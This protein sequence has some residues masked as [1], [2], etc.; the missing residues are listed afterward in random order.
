MSASRATALCGTPERIGLYIGFRSS[1]T[2][3]RLRVICMSCTHATTGAASTLHTLGS[4][5]DLRTW[6]TCFQRVATS[7]RAGWST[8]E[9]RSLRSLLKRSG[10]DM[11]RTAKP[12]APWHWLASSTYRKELFRQCFA[13]LHGSSHHDRT[14]LANSLRR[15]GQWIDQNITK[16]YRSHSA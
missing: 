10:G 13:A 9:G 3:L 2:T 12:M 11:C 14:R 6:L 7:T 1:C 4:E 15:R 8:R 16:T 5:L